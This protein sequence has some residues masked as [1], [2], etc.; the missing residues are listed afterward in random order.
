MK[1][2]TPLIS[3]IMPAYN[4]A[5]FVEKTIK[6]VLSQSFSN[7]EF[8]IIND[9]ST[10]NTE[11]ICNKYA[12]NTNITLINTDNKGVSSARN[13]GLKMAKGKYICFIDSDDILDTKYLEVLYTLIEK[14]NAEL[15]AC[16]VSKFRLEKN[17]TPHQLNYIKK[18]L[19][20]DTAPL[21]IFDRNYAGYLHSKIFKLETIKNNNLLLDNNL[22]MLEDEVFVLE[23]LMHAKKVITID[24]ELYNYRQ[25][26]KS[27]CHNFKNEKWFTIF[28]ALNRIMDIIEKNNIKIA[29]PA[30]HYQFLYFLYEGLYRVKFIDHKLASAKKRQ[31]KKQIRKIYNKKPTFTAKQKI[32]LFIYRNFNSFSFYARSFYKEHIRR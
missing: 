14:N 31:I 19:D 4:T 16:K 21:L 24:A 26:Q 13:T 5:D 20:K 22:A 17:I 15:A 29:M 27:I 25:N 30:I 9:G 3:V 2:N 8:I 1:K 23:Y 11:E 6:S 32:K 7:F 10:D 18:T 28:D 12:S